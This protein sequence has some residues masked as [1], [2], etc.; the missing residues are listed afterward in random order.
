MSDSSPEKTP[1]IELPDRAV[2]EQLASAVG[3][4]PFRI[5]S[6]VIELGS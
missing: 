1:E 6:A 5:A 4:Q 3:Q 2:L